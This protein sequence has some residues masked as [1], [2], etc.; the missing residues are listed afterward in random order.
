MWS[1]WWLANSFNHGTR[2][3]EASGSLG[4]Q[5]QP[6]LQTEFQDS[7]GYTDRPWRKTKCGFSTFTSPL[8]STSLCN[9]LHRV[10]EMLLLAAVLGTAVSTTSRMY[11]KLK[12]THNKKLAGRNKT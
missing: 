1:E 9:T 10:W 4:I 2:K 6:G 3:S 7:Q 11:N 12:H 8:L 5:G